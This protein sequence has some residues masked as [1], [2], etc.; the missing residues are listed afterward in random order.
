M[1]DRITLESPSAEWLRNIW[2]ERSW[3]ITIINSWMD[4]EYK[5]LTQTLHAF[6]TFDRWLYEQIY[7]PKSIKYKTL[8]AEEQRLLDFY[9]QFLSN[10]EQCM[11][12]ND[13][14]TKNLALVAAQ[15]WGVPTSPDEWAPSSHHELDK[16]RL[17]LLQLAR[18]WSSDGVQERQNTYGRIIEAI[19]SRILK[20]SRILVPG[21][22]L[23]RLVYEF[24]RRGYWTQGNEVSYHMLLTLGFVLNRMPMAHSHSIFPYMFKLSHVARRLFQV[25]AVTIPDESPHKIFEGD[26]NQEAGDL[27]SMVAGSFVDLYGPRDLALSEAYT[28]DANAAE[29]RGENA[30]AFDAVTTCFFLDTAHN[31]IDYIKTIH[32]CLRDGGLWVNFG[33]LLWHYEGDLTALEVTRSTGENEKETMNTIMQGMEL[34]RDELFSLIEK[35]GFTIEESE[36]GN[37]TT[38][39]GDPKAL[40]N[41]VYDAEFWVARKIPEK[42]YDQTDER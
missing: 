19:E 16:V 31:V 2:R 23:G 10:L 20:K 42:N 3:I 4:E 41:F 7:K 1:C 25:R 39:C 12:I 30:E 6:Y 33:P 14:F 22:G 15:D 32:H 37:L 13:S 11:G 36:S 27:M 38:Y 28:D 18:E 29:F 5:A 21:C 26:E 34:S 17:T 8:S 24:V 9:P 40:G 35:M